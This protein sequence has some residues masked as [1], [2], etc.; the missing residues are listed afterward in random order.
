MERDR[1]EAVG[2]LADVHATRAR[3]ARVVVQGEPS[4]FPNYRE[5]LFAD[6]LRLFSPPCDFFTSTT[7]PCSATRTMT[8]STHR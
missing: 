7:Y 3:A 2:W 1:R 4:S 6:K 5:A 8:A